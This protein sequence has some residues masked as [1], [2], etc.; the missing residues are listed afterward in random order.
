MSTRARVRMCAPY[1]AAVRAIVVTSRASSSSCP[2]HDSRPP[3]SPAGR[4][5]GAIRSTSV[6][7]TRRERGRVCESVPAERRST[8]PA[9]SAARDFGG[10]RAGNRR[11]ERE[12]D[13]HRVGEVRRGDLHQDAALDGALVGDAD[14]T[15]G[16]VAQPAVDELG[17]PARG[18]E[19][20]VVGVDGEHRQAPGDRVERDP[21]A[22]DAEPDDDHVDVGGRAV[23]PGCDPGRGHGV[24]IRVRRVASSSSSSASETSSSTIVCAEI[25]KP[26]VVSTSARAI[27]VESPLRTSPAA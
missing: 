25:T 8:S 3:R 18:A 19:R 13:R 5:G 22:G 1:S 23:E 17:R 20:E 4:S 12:H 2:S 15:R 9:S 7:D 21:G 26:W 24:S 11:A 27:A 10:Q 16:E 6:L 14:L